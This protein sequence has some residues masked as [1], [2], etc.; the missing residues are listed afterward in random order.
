K[1]SF[2]RWR[3]VAAALAGDEPGGRALALVRDARARGLSE[4]EVERRSPPGEDPR[5]ALRVLEEEGRV[6][7]T[8]EGRWVEAGLVREVEDAL[9]ALVGRFHEERPLLFGVSPRELETQL[10]APLR[11]LS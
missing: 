3:E 8:L 11:G 2:R 1:G 5:A 10:P 9:L 7:R 4:E 6:V